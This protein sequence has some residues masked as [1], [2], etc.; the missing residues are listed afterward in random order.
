MNA[1]AFPDSGWRYQVESPCIKICAIDPQTKLCTGCGRTLVEIEAWAGLSADERRQI[2][3]ELAARL[4][5]K[6]DTA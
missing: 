5:A 1:S 4:R 2:M 3:T 6:A